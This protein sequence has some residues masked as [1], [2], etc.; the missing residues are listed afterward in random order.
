[1]NKAT[2]DIIEQMEISTSHPRGIS[3]PRFIII[4]KPE[5]SSSCMHIS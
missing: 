3:E 5:V 2:L 4:E 1:M